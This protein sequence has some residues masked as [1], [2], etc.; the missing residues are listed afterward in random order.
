[1]ISNS[2]IHQHLRTIIAVHTFQAI[3]NSYSSTTINERDRLFFSDSSQPRQ[4]AS[5]PRAGLRMGSAGRAGR[6]R[7]GA[8]RGEQL[9]GVYWQHDACLPVGP[10]S[11][12]SA[13]VAARTQ[14]PHWLCPSRT[15]ALKVGCGCET[16]IMTFGSFVGEDVSSRLVLEQQALRIVSRYW[17]VSGKG[18]PVRLRAGKT[19]K[20]LE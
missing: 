19:N 20:L 8:G 1:M 16:K 18:I 14:Y 9:S 10:L 15:A 13:D 2:L 6:L 17:E 11:L 3:P 5:A 12:R 4:R 7:A